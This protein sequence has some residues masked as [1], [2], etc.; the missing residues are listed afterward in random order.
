M[1]FTKSTALL[2]ALEIDLPILLR[3]LVFSPELPEVDLVTTLD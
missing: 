2:A 3:I 1:I